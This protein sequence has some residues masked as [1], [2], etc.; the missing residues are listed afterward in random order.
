MV[1]TY[2]QVLQYVSIRF[3]LICMLILCLLPW[4]TKKY[5]NS[6]TSM[7]IASW[8]GSGVILVAALSHMVSEASDAF[9]FCFEDDESAY[10]Y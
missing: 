4:T 8:F 10:S 2:Y 3:T 6:A 7:S 9:Y 5:K 1:E